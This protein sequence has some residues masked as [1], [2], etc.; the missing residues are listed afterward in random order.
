M[1][2]PKLNV[3]SFCEA[4]D[5]KQDELNLKTVEELNNER[6]E[7]KNNTQES[8]LGNKKE[9]N[10]EPSATVTNIKESEATM[11]KS[12]RIS[13]KNVKLNNQS[14]TDT[15]RSQTNETSL[16]ATVTNDSSDKTNIKA[17]PDL[18]VGSIS[19]VLNNSLTN[20]KERSN[21]CLEPKTPSGKSQSSLDDLVSRTPSLNES[22]TSVDV[23]MSSDC[24]TPSANTDTPKLSKK[25]AST[26]PRRLTPKQLLKMKEREAKLKE[27]A[28]L[29]QVKS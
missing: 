6:E 8:E 5:K 20:E 21:S 1:D 27:R 25:S 29:K 15:E 11:D 2:L 14:T 7:D 22:S 13:E 3:E 10:S 18:E 23:S 26:T 4:K 24:S 9:V 28:H 12:D 19:K 17:T 16:E